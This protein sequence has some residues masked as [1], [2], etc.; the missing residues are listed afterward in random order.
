M[1]IKAKVKRTGEELTLKSFGFGYIDAKGRFFHKTA[2][3]L[4][5]IIKDE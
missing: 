1:K 5:G 4:L 3:K 2:I